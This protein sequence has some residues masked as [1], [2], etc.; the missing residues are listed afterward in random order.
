MNVLRSRVPRTMAGAVVI[1]LHA[2]AQAALVVTAPRLPLDAG[3]ITLAV[4]SGLVMLA[5]AAALWTLALRAVS[6][7]ALL[8]LAVAGLAVAA[9]AVA[10]P[11]VVPFVVA[12]A[13]PLIAAASP[14]AAWTVARR[15]PWRTVGSLIVTGVAVVLATIVA[16][17]FGLLAPGALGVAAAWAVIGGGAGVFMGIWA[18]WARAAASAA[19]VQP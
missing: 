8:T 13:S 10:A 7:P 3:A 18:R 2:A 16:M 15:H 11:I 14:F 6:A 9:G 1:L 12:L 4:V 17:L 5:A 19:P